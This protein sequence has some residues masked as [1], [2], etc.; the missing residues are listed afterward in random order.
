MVKSIIYNTAGSFTQSL[1][2]AARDIILRPGLNFAALD[3]MRGFAS[4]IVVFYHCVS[5]SGPPTAKADTSGYF[6]WLYPLAN[7]MWSGIDI[8]F[9]LSGFLIGRLL[10]ID[11]K[12]WN[13]IY[14]RR[15]LIRRFCR[16]F[17]AYYLILLF[18]VFVIANIEKLPPSYSLLFGSVDIG[19]LLHNCWANF[20]YVNNYVR[21][22]SRGD[23]FSWGWSLCV[24]EHFYLILP[25]LLWLLFRYARPNGQLAGL[26]L[27]AT[28]PLIGRAVQYLQNPSIR[29]TD[30]LYYYSHNRFDEIFCGVIVAYFYV[31]KKDV[32]ANFVN[33]LG[34]GV[35]IIGLI[36]I[37]SVWIFGGLQ[38]GGA[39]GI[40]WQF[41]LLALGSSLLLV[42]G[43]FSG[44]VA[45]RFFSHPAWYPLARISYGTFLIHPFVLFFV[46]DNIWPG[47]KTEWTIVAIFFMVMSLSTIMAAVMFAVLE[48]N[49]LNI[50][51]RWARKYG[52]R[53]CHKELNANLIH[54]S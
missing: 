8:F 5:F 47:A 15:F 21:P 25:P 44:N 46:L 33:R 18:A 43:L 50:G 4:I 12:E 53:P 9:V 51:V 7:G 2:R 52:P 10:I 41:T 35:W 36:C 34:H 48:R 1:S 42:N 20:I 38:K 14:Y 37:G 49:F 29:L 24:E 16:I 23:I 39:F 17:P 19:T 11:L 54:S 45:S 3:G 30:G 13:T 27:C 26:V 22:E 6:L 31:Y 40:V 32:L 28:L